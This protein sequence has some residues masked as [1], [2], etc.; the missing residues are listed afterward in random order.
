[1]LTLFHAD[2]AVCAAKVRVTLAEKN[3]P[4]ES[5]MIDLGRG[6][7]FK[8][9][10]LAVNPNAAVPVIIH[11][12]KW[13]NESTVINEYLDDAFAN[14]PLRPSD[15]YGR[16]R[17]HLWTKREDSIHDCIN[18]MTVAVV[19]RADL[20]DKPPEVRRARYE[21]I[22]DAAKREKWRQLLE[23]GVDSPIVGEAL[24]R[25]NK[26]F[27]DM[28]QALAEGPWLC[29]EAFTLADI[30]F[31]S[32]FYRMEAMEAKGIWEKHYPRVTDWFN[33]CKA[34]PSFRTAIADYIPAPRA[35]HFTRVSE[36]L[37]ETIERRFDEAM[38]AS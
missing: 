29:G 6:D 33:R 5:R 10:Y 3:I 17:V 32:F 26:L 19:F 13:L 23:L 36:P 30:G 18:T 38:Q 9:E 31:I 11:D 24:G 12:G 21:S 34:R 4:F 37:R 15:A 20:L 8:P 25:F 28:E 27:R 22:P 35:A 14:P 7:Q 16:A 1:M 2:T